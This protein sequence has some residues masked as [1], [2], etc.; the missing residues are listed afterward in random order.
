MAQQ[1]GPSIGVGILGCS[2]I[3]RRKFV[4]ALL[5]SDIARLAAVAARDLDKAAR[6][7][8][9]E[10]YAVLEPEELVVCPEVELVYISLPNHLHEEWTLRALEGGKHVICEKPVGLTV[11]SVEKMFRSAE[12]RGLLLFENL[13]FLQH[14]QHAAVKETVEAG[15]IGRITALRSVFGFP[16]PGNG[17]FRLNADEGGG[18]FNDLARYPLATALYFLEGDRYRFQGV[19]LDHDG[20]NLAMH[21]L[22]VTSAREVF[23]FS[24]V[25]GQQYESFYEIIGEEGKIRVDRAYTTPVDLANEVR[26]TCGTEDASFI[27]PP[28]DHFRL[29]LDHVCGVLRGKNFRTVHDRS[30]RIA[31]LAEEMKNGCIHG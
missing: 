9:A 6:F 12:E 2:D 3:A 31:R 21:G 16:R 7:I 28:A 24:M 11:R 8:P 25:F 30:R 14:P 1:T 4:P 15:R 5:S 22:A 19:S 13:M 26:V 20:L 10:T 29:T 18:A 27:V 17:D 23:T